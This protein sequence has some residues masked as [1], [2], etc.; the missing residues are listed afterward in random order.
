M[1]GPPMAIK[2]KKTE[3]K[4]VRTATVRARIEPGLKAEAE[5]IMEQL[6]VSPS[7]FVRMGYAQVVLRRG[8][9]FP[10]EIPNAETAKVLRAADAGRG[11]KRYGSVAEMAK[12]LGD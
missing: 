11:L 5:R 8:L 12:A 1:E 6:G 10:V 7:D 4:A 9:P 2:A 3:A